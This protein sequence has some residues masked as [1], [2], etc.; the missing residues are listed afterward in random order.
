MPW[1]EPTHLMEII[2]DLDG[3]SDGSYKPLNEVDYKLAHILQ[4]RHADA[5]AKWAKSLKSDRMCD[6]I[7]YSHEA[8]AYDNILRELTDGLPFAKGF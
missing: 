8:R 7:K 4:K 3:R 6:V 1:D 5:E 2:G